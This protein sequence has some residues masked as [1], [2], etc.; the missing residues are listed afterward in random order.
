VGEL[1]SHIDDWMAFYNHRRKQHEGQDGD[2]SWKGSSPSTSPFQARSKHK[3][4]RPRNPYQ[5]NEQFTGN[6]SGTTSYPRY[7]PPL[8]LL[9]R[10]LPA[11][12]FSGGRR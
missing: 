3:P 6:E 10:E 9:V 5:L 4:T 2:Y 12:G 7:A 11:D 8:F 1:R